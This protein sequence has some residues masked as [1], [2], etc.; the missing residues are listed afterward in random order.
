MNIEKYLERINYTKKNSIDVETL[1]GLQEAHLKSI[2]F[3]NLDIH[4]DRKIE[5]N[6]PSLFKKIIENKRGGLCYELNAL[7][8]QLLKEIGFDVKMISARVYNNIGDT[9]NLTSY[10]PDYD[11]MA[12]IATLK[13]QEFLLDVGFGEF[14]LYSLPIKLN[15]ILEDPLGK[16]TFDKFNEKYFRVN[17]IVVE[18]G[19][20]KIIPQY[21][22]ETQS[23]NL[24]EFEKMCIFHQTSSESIFTKGMVIYFL[25]EYKLEK[26]KEYKKITLTDNKLKIRTL[27]NIVEEEL[28]FEDTKTDKTQFEKL[29]FEHF[30]IKL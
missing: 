25:K 6:I 15:T 24:E 5:L 20:E 7:F 28:H 13:Q 16:F 14:S 29:L 1:N 11:H 3:E 17:E 4:Y 2:P 12:I 30:S 22:F 27:D 10:N 23:R 18:D 26:G 9:E 21:L 8:Y 19:K